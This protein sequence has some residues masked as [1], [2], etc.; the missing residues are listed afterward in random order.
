MNLKIPLAAVVLVAAVVTA[1]YLWP[2]QQSGHSPAVAEKIVPAPQNKPVP[3]TTYQ[4]A[5]THDAAEDQ[6][7][8]TQAVEGPVK[9]IAKLSPEVRV[10][11]TKMLNTSSEGLV[12]ET[13][14]G[15][16]SMHLQG[17]FQ[18]VPVATIDEAGNASIT[19]YSHLNPGY[20][21]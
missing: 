3:V 2:V 9:E 18:T 15:V 19:D 12:T 17:R 10:A 13:V 4:H 21:P 14:N 1:L 16:T 6:I 20:K 11:L 7:A 5:H 8:A